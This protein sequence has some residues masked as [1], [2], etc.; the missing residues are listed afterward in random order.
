MVVVQ[1]K[2]WGTVLIRYLVCRHDN[3]SDY[4]AA[5]RIPYTGF[6]AFKWSVIERTV[7]RVGSG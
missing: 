7:Y 6:Y 3:F 4:A 2:L 1:V 5:C